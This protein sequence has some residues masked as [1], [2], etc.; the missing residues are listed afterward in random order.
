MEAGVDLDFPV[1]YRAL[2]GLDSIAQ[3]AGRCNREGRLFDLGRV[4]VFVPPSEPP[5]GHLRQARDAGRPLLLRR[6]PDPLA[7]ERFT[8]YFQSL[9]WRKGA[10]GLDRQD[11]TRLLRNNQKLEFSFRTAAE[12]F[13]LIPETQAPVIGRYGDMVSA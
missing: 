2:A 11:I 3:A 10:A 1:V 9:Y 8:E 5:A 12:R 4:V 7:P 13:Q 6:P